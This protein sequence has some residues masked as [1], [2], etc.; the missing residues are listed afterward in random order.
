VGYPTY[1][2]GFSYSQVNNIT[3]NVISNQYAAYNI[4][5]TGPVGTGD[6][7]STY[8]I[9]NSYYPGNARILLPE[10]TRPGFMRVTNTTYTALAI[11]DGDPYGFSRPFADGDYFILKILGF[12]AQNVSTGITEIYLA[13]Y[14]NGQSFIRREWS[15]VDLTGLGADTKYIDFDFISTDMNPDHP[16]WGINTPAYF[17]MDNFTVT[18]VPEPTSVGLVLT[19]GYLGYRRWKRKS[20]NRDNQPNR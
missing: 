15:T 17:A 10:N 5:S 2:S 19:V 8:A 7:S 13:D 9:V 12:N 3:T 11:R 4:P 6:N 16:E 20:Q 18:P 14:R 1:W